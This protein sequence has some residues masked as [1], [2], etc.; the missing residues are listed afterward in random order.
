M[1]PASLNFDLQDDV[2]V[3]RDVVHRWVEERV[4][5]LAPRRM[6]ENEFPAEFRAETGELGFPGISD[7]DEHGDVGMSN[8]AHT[9]AV[10]DIARAKASVALNC[11]FHFNHCVNTVGINGIDDQKA[12]YLP[13]LIYCESA[14]ALAMS[15]AGAGSDVVGMKLRVE[16]RNGYVKLDGTRFWINTVEKPTLLS[17]MPLPILRLVQRVRQHSLSKKIWP[18]SA[19]PINSTSQV[20]AD[21]TR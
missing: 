11:V 1:F 15:E 6:N 7:P 18:V 14:A 5:P 8:P 20:C 13:G 17:S 4:K 2:T 21:R 9:I 12:R 16:K 10:E 3:L 19:N